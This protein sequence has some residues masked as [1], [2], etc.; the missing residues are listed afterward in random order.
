[1]RCGRSN[2]LIC[3]LPHAL[4]L[5]P[6]VTL[7]RLAG[8]SNALQGLLKIQM[9]GAWSAVCSAGFGQEEAR[10]ACRQAGLA[11]GAVS[12]SFPKGRLPFAVANVVCRGNEPNLAACKYSLTSACLGAKPVG[13]VCQSE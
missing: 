11:G 12:N 4:T 2:H 7:A 5:I 13:L 8:G 10:V 1:M 3:L 6:A 9:G